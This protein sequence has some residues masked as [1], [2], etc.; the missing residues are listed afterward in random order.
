MKSK[1]VSRSHSRRGPPTATLGSS[2]MPLERAP[3]DSARQLNARQRQFPGWRQC[4]APR[5]LP[6]SALETTPP[7]TVDDGLLASSKAPLRQACKPQTA[8]RS[9]LASETKDVPAGT[10]I[11]H[12]NARQPRSAITLPRPRNVLATASRWPSARTLFAVRRV[13]LRTVDDGLLATLPL[14]HSAER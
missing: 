5:P 1:T 10:P 6:Q 12:R 4:K 3:R 7:A 9:V 8:M 13:H 11:R 2:T 14:P